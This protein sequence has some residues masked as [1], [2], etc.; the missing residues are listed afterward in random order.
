MWPRKQIL[1][2]FSVE[3]NEIRMGG[4]L[5]GF[6]VFIGFIEFIDLTQATQVTQ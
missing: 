4:S 3:L 6:V 5:S 1:R 2:T